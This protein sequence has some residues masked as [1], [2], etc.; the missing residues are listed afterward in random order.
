MQPPGIAALGEI[1]S[2]GG[3]RLSVDDDGWMLTGIG[4]GLYIRA[5]C[6]KLHGRV[7]STRW[8][9]T[10]FFQGAA[11]EYME[12][13]VPGLHPAPG[14]AVAGR[15]GADGGNAPPF[16]WRLTLALR[17]GDLLLMRLETTLDESDEEVVLE[18]VQLAPLQL[19]ALPGGERGPASDGAPPRAPAPA[20]WPACRP[21]AWG[22]LLRQVLARDAG[23]RRRSPEHSSFLV[24]GWQSFSF[25]GVLHGAVPQ[26]RT[27]MP[28]FSGAF[29]DGAS[30]P[31]GAE[32][33]DGAL[34]SDMFGVFWLHG[35]GGAV[36]GFLRQCGGF[37]GVAAL[38][39]VEP[40]RL[41]LFSEAGVALRPGVAVASDWA[42]VA[43]FGPAQDQRHVEALSGA[44]SLRHVEAGACALRLYLELVALHCGVQR[45]HPRP[46]GWCS[47]YCHGPT[48]NMSL[49][50]DSLQK[51]VGERDR[52]R[53]P[54]NLFQLDDGWQSA[55]GD[56]LSPNLARFPQGLRPLAHKIKNVG[57]TPGIW[58]APAAL[59]SHSR[60]A[61]EH[62]DWILRASDGKP[63]KCGFTAPG[64]WMQALDVTNP[65]V[66]EHISKVIG[67]IVHEWGFR[68][69]KCDFL[70]CAS[71]SAGVRH[72]ATVSRAAALERLM[73]TIRKAAGERV[74][75]LA[76]GAPLGPCIGHVDAARVSADT[77]EHWLPKGP[78]VWGTRWFFARDRT[79]LPAARN[80]VR[81]TMVRLAMGEHLW[82]NDPDCLIL[83]EDVP[84]DEARALATVAAMSAGSLILSDNLQEMVPERLA[85]LE[86]L[87][88]PL[89]RP[90]EDVRLLA[91]EIPTLLA[92]SLQP[93]PSVDES[94]WSLV[95]L[96]SWPEGDAA[97]DEMV[98]LPVAVPE[99]EAPTEW[100]VFEFW[101]GSYELLATAHGRPL[102]RPRRAVPGRCTCQLLAV[103][104][105][106]RARAQFVGSNV[107][108]SCGLELGS[109]GQS[110]CG[111]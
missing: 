41:L 83:R 70:H 100:H 88:P 57:L 82:I 105:V 96:F 18:R 52:R 29:H 92:T 5:S 31:E 95:S 43:P 89:P 59:V 50:E 58:L 2:P 62:P 111:A 27:C 26:P 99:G 38:D 46:L 3:S 10:L 68:Y 48:V 6:P 71:M 30:L 24:N 76:C 33:S 64:L 104:R 55:W 44:C 69:L 56:W 107:H 97:P 19:H 28:F 78:D 98:E 73:S 39:A 103:R 11:L 47:W 102:I 51:L 34:V 106:D 80:M 17:Q 79:N 109:F 86:C 7:G 60:V 20:G 49:M 9:K 75:V 65:A 110:S 63:V 91:P 12:V 94:S 8:A 21:Q 40:P 53:L 37:G 74:F 22:K 42:V 13:A 90:A 25:S 66:V 16:S 35:L 85:L 4:P 32:G 23:T 81:N 72:D 54:C 36:A 87:V 15:C 101:S 108:V 1:M 61:N 67:T 93:K 84:L 14:L 45:R 77:A